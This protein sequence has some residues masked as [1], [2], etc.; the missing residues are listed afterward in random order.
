MHDYSDSYVNL[1]SEVFLKASVD[2]QERTYE[3][4]LNL[5]YSSSHTKEDKWKSNFIMF[6]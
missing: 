5:E 3:P 6:Y 1:V 4:H 2:L